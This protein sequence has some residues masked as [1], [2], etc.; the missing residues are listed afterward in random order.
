MSLPSDARVAQGKAEDT[1]VVYSVEE[2]DSDNIM[3]FFFRFR[4]PQMLFLSGNLSDMGQ[5]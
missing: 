4:Y 5:S 1:V 2:K 3:I